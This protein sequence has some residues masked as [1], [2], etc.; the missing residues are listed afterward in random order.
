MVS[1]ILKAVTRVIGWAALSFVSTF[2]FKMIFQ[3]AKNLFSG[4][5]SIL[6]WDMR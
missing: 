2:F 1:E 4:L 3:F 6:N 5:V